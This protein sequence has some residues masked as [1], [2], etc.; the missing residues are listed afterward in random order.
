MSEKINNMKANILRLLAENAELKRELDEA[1]AQN[2]RLRN[3]N[4]PETVI[5]KDLIENLNLWAERY[6]GKP[7]SLSLFRAVTILRELEQERDETR[8]LLSEKIIQ[9][10]ITQEELEF[11][12]C[13]KSDV[14]TIETDRLAE[15]F[16]RNTLP[17]DVKLDILFGFTRKLEQEL[18]KTQQVIKEAWLAMDE[19]EGTDRMNDWQNKHVTILEEVK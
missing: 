8:V 15:E 11:T 17:D 1:Q 13:I 2:A 4:T 18:I 5:I 19:I 16:K 3:I 12:K 9:Y 14:I 6:K 10:E 7:I